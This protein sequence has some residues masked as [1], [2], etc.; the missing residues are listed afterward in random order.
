[1]FQPP[2]PLITVVLAISLDGKIADRQH[3]PARF[4]SPADKHHLELQIAK[5]D[6]VLLGASTLRSYGTTLCIS[7]PELLQQRQSQNKP[8]QPTHIVC[9]G[10]GNLDPQLAFFRQSIPRWLLTTE[11]GAQQWGN[12]DGFERIIQAENALG[13]VDWI[14]ALQTLASWDCDRVAALGG[15][16]LIA[17]LLT[18]DCIDEFWITVC[19]LIL[20]GRTAPTLVEGE[21]YLEAIAPRLELIAAQP[22]D[23]EVFLHYRV[24]Q[25]HQ[26]GQPM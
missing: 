6:A 8:P 7:D 15:G 10:S 23:Q 12:K 20:G 25:K 18:A 4:G 19:P 11:I 2:R 5:A 14:A 3:A 9:S 13:T 21:G 16:E 1:M 26:Q 24:K 22:I 17:G